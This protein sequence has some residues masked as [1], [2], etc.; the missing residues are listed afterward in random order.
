[1]P[2]DVVG[3]LIRELRARAPTVLV[4]ED[5]HWADEATLDVLRL[6]AGRMANVPALVLATYRDDEL[7]R[8]H[9][10][11]AVL[12]S[13]ATGEAVAACGSAAL[14][15]AVAT[16][17]E[18]HGLD[19]DELYRRTAGN[20]FFVTEV[21]GGREQRSRHGAGRGARADRPRLSHAAGGCW[22]RSRS[23]RRRPSSGSSRRL[24]APRLDHLE[25]C[26]AAGMLTPQPDGVAFRHELA[27]LAVEE[28]LPPDRGSR[29][30]RKALA[31]LGA[32]S[33]AAPTSPRLAHH[34]DA[35]GDAAAVLALRAPGPCA[36]PR[37][38]PS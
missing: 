27:R 24:P 28:S 3:A 36:Q 1:M 16:L 19:A 20:P 29:L 32:R 8:A 33:G 4:L 9:P 7:E 12:G 21:L 14:A 30:H 23:R 15:E 35:A 37:S 18:P 22:R 34:A 11:R 2:Y 10:L 26:L 31:A 17:A 13:S 25:E 5:L 38:A 6:L